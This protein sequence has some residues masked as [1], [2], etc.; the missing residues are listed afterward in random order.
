MS[1]AVD[2][3][4]DDVAVAGIP[5][6]RV[7]ARFG[8]GG[9]FTHV[10]VLNVLGVVLGFATWEIAALSVNST[11]V[12]PTPVQ[13]ADAFVTLFSDPDQLHH[14]ASTMTRVVL[15]FLMGSAVGIV[16]GSLIGASRLGKQVLEPFLHFFR[17]VSPI[18]WLVPAA[19]WFGIGS[20]SMMFV[21]IYATSFPVIINTMTGMARVPDNK[22]RMCQMFGYGRLI[23]FARIRLPSSVPFILVGMRL[24]LGYAFM[25]A[26][27]VEM[28]VGTSG[29]GFLMYDARIL[30][31]TPLMFAGIIAIGVFGYLSDMIFQI[32]RDGLFRRYLKV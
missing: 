29:L 1:G 28:I 20:S 26:I 13:A 4:A 21:I 8:A 3:R 2:A 30:F 27:G 5:T 14:V 31:N 7:Q 19:I 25:S 11:L 9:R 18:A 23:E 16:V 22:L 10:R 15:G 12:L 24:A 6:R 17:S 32:A